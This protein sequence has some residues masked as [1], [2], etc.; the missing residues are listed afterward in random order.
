MT[1]ATSCEPGVPFQGVWILSPR[2][3]R[4]TEIVRGVVSCI[5]LFVNRVASHLER[6]AEKKQEPGQGESGPSPRGR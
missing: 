5:V 4:A 2:Q 6:R 3:L 1:K